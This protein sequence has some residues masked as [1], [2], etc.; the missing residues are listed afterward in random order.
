[1]LW[2][3]KESLK[4]LFS[5]LSGVGGAAGPGGKLLSQDEFLIFCRACGLIGADLTERDATLA[6]S[7]SRVCVCDVSDERGQAR[8]S[9]LPFEGFLEALVHI[10]LLKGA[11]PSTP[12]RPSSTTR[13]PPR[14]SYPAPPS[15]LSLSHRRRDRVC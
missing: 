5:G 15:P 3:Y 11:C 9:Q 4:H 6:F 8:D 13:P 2:P 7:W 10:A 12:T 1:M 14:P